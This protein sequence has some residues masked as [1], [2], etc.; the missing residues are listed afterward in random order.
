M[1]NGLTSHLQTPPAN[2]PPADPEL[3][4]LVCSTEHC[5]QKAAERHPSPLGSGLSVPVTFAF[6]VGPQVTAAQWD[7]L[8]FT[9][10]T[11]MAKQE[12]KVNL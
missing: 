2:Q 1:E 6:Y 8:T 3:P 7:P 9:F 5:G 4:P 10:P 12:M 11:T